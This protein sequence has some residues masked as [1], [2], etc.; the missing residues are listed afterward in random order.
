MARLITACF[1]IILATTLATAQDVVFSLDAN[2]NSQSCDESISYTA[3]G[4]TDIADRCSNAVSAKKLCRKRWIPNPN[5][6][7]SPDSNWR[8]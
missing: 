5:A 4:L 1:A 6:D 8:L 2:D 7:K 3:T